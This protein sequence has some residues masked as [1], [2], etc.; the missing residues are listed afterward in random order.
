MVGGVGRRRLVELGKEDDK[1]R[2]IRF[3]EMTV[4]REKSNLYLF[5]V[6]TDL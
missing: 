1:A 2:A 4:I 3:R 5:V 6:T